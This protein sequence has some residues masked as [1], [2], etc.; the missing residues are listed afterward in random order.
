MFLLGQFK[1]TIE[2]K[3]CAN[4]EPILKWL[5][6]YLCLFSCQESS[7]ILNRFML[8]GSNICEKC[9]SGDNTNFTRRNRENKFSRDYVERQ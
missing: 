4:F 9:T 3:L 5:F 6:F 7:R 2:N 1:V 8:V